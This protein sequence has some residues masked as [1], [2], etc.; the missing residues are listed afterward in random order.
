MVTLIMMKAKVIIQFV[1][2]SLLYL[3][4]LSDAVTGLNSHNPDDLKQRSYQANYDGTAFQ[5]VDGQM[6]CSYRSR[7]PNKIRIEAQT[8]IAEQSNVSPFK[9]FQQELSLNQPS[10]SIDDRKFMKH[11]LSHPRTGLNVQSHRRDKIHFPRND[12]QLKRYNNES[13]FSMLYD[14]IIP[15]LRS[16]KILLSMTGMAMIMISPTSSWAVE[17]FDGSSITNPIV[18]SNLY[19]S[20][21]Q[22]KMINLIVSQFVA[23]IVFGLIASYTSSFML[24]LL[25][26]SDIPKT[27][28]SKDSINNI[29]DKN[30]SDSERMVNPF[31]R[32][33]IDIVAL[34]ICLTIDCIG[35]LSEVIPGG[36]LFDIIWAPIAG[37]LLRSL[38]NNNNVLLLGEIVEELLPF[39]TDLLPF[40]TICWVID[41]FLETSDIAKL[42]QL[43]QYKKIILPSNKR[44]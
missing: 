41:T 11:V 19:W 10:D 17:I 13:H 6:R 37:L 44:F 31:D 3:S 9:F 29:S 4:R 20:S 38:Y 34:L 15:I 12:K 40:A 24:R 22:N 43:G 32:Y 23:T 28:G 26:A 36:Y 42:L 8:I 35:S 16:Q 5:I 27:N 14:N 2:F 18:V 33:Q 21:L 7:R 30:N 25:S 39:G 1:S